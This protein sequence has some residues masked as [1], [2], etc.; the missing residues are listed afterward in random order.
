MAVLLALIVAG[1]LV[2]NGDEIM[3]LKQL[4]DWILNN[5]ILVLLGLFMILF[6]LTNT[7]NF[8]DFSHYSFTK[9]TE[10]GCSVQCV[11]SVSVAGGI[12]CDWEHKICKNK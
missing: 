3:Q 9:T 7:I 11:C 10:D 4:I 1:A 5:P 2:L 8:G 6:L 12:S